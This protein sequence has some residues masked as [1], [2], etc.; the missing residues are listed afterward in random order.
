MEKY[1][2]CNLYVLSLSLLKKNCTP[3]NAWDPNKVKNIDW[4]WLDFGDKRSLL[5]AFCVPE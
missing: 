1:D 2:W 3:S 4:E 5:I